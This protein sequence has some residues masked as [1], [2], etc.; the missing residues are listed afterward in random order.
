[1]AKTD[2]TQVIGSNW[3]QDPFYNN[4]MLSSLNKEHLSFRQRYFDFCAQLLINLPIK[5]FTKLLSTKTKVNTFNYRLK[6]RSSFSI[7]PKFIASAGHGDDVLLLFAMSNSTYKFTPSDLLIAKTFAR[8]LSSFAAKGT[9]NAR[10]VHV[11]AFNEINSNLLFQ[12][13]DSNDSSRAH[14]SYFTHI[15]SFIQLIKVSYFQILLLSIKFG[16]M[17]GAQSDGRIAIKVE[18]SSTNGMIC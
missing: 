4:L 17:S 6:Y 3:T 5:Q 15:L 9:P 18:N 16:V 8:S 11:S 7:L 10:I 1:M 14:I 13:M 2:L 12:R